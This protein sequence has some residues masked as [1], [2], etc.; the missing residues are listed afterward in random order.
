LLTSFLS[1][2]ERLAR[3]WVIQKDYERAA[4]WANEIISKD[5]LWE[6]AYIQL[7]YCYWKQG[8]RALAVRVYDRCKKRLS[9]ALNLAPSPRAQ[10]LLQDII[11]G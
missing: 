3:L 10:D 2:S 9:E 6:E 5:P 8:N 1:A 7:M 4:Y 11:H